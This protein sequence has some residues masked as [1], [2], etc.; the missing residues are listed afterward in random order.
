MLNP[1]QNRS[2]FDCAKPGLIEDINSRMALFSL[3]S[4]VSAM[5]TTW[6]PLATLTIYKRGCHNS[7]E[8]P[9]LG[10]FLPFYMIAINQIK[11]CHSKPHATYRLW[12][13]I[14][15]GWYHCSKTIKRF[16]IDAKALDPSINLFEPDIKEA[17]KYT[18]ATAKND[19]SNRNRSLP[20][21]N[22]YGVSWQ[23]IYLKRCIRS[24]FSYALT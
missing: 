11:I 4:Y 22:L 2:L 18:S 16:A 13:T 15:L 9:F 10:G 21:K 23:R 1:R 7:T 24:I 20:G 8:T 14:I 17:Q 5:K 12:S 19:S 3:W 6:K